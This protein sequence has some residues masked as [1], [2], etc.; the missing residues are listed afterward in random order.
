MFV[1]MRIQSFDFESKSLPLPVQIETKMMGFLPV[2]ATR[3]D[4]LTDFPNA[5]ITEVRDAK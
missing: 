4:A 1:V 3:E 2:Y 5:Q